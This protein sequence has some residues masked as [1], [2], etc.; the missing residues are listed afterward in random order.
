[1]LDPQVTQP[2]FECQRHLL[3]TM[4]LWRTSGTRHYL[5]CLL[6]GVLLADAPQVGGPAI[7]RLLDGPGDLSRGCPYVVFNLRHGNP[8]K[9]ALQRRAS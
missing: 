3:E 2:M 8:V 6:E 9:W 5:A 4:R 7:V 1:M